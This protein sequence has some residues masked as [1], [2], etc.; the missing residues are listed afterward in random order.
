MAGNPRIADAPYE[1]HVGVWASEL[2]QWLPDTVFDAHVH[3]G[4]AE[5]MGALTPERLAEPL[6]TFTHFTWQTLSR[7]HAALFPGRRMAGVAAFP[8]PL[9]EVDI[10]RANAYIVD[11][12]ERAA[13][14]A[15]FLLA[16][17]TDARQAQQT[18]E[19][20]MAR[21]VRFRGVKPYF[22]LL[23]KS[24]YETTMP[25]FIPEALLDMMDAEGLVMMLHTSGV[26]MGDPQSQG[27]VRSVLDRHPHVRIILAHMG[28]YLRVEDFFR[29]CE[30]DL[31]SH[32]RLYLEMSSATLPEVY[33]R[34]LARTETHDRLLF[35]TDLP[36]GLISGVEV[37][38]QETGPTFIT[39]DRFVWT[40]ESVAE[41]FAER[42]TGLT[43][44]TYHAITALKAALEVVAPDEKRAEQLKRKVFAE[45]AMRLLQDAP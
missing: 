26:G 30:T 20:A 9:R 42:A 27:Y 7:W 6:A 23:G 37:W 13:H 41:R 14:V 28:R 40:D 12:M 44:N 3:V 21:G 8:F 1:D 31:L 17:P 35:G 29:F 45:N 22:D 25:E 5:A 19:A 11:V 38:S 36:Y 34:T 4:P 10:E 33:E 18:Y 24:N 2:S 39:R 32:P 15:G 43:Y 16:H